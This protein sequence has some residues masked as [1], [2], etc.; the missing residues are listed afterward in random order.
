VTHAD[1]AAPDARAP[2]AGWW[3]WTAL[4]ATDVA[5]KQARALAPHTLSRRHVVA[6]TSLLIDDRERQGH[7]H[8]ASQPR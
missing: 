7:P 6:P 4:R 2:G 5:N 1:A 8:R 3:W